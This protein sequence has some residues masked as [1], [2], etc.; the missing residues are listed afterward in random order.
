MRQNTKE[1]TFIID[2]IKKQVS[3]RLK[4]ADLVIKNSD[5]QSRVSSLKSRSLQG[6]LDN[7]LKR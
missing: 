3:S 5:N 2:K 4:G 6:R 7:T 1:A